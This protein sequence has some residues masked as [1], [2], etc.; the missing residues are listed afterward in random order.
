GDGAITPRYLGAGAARVIGVDIDE[1]GIAR[2]RERHSAGGAEFLPSAPDRIPLADGSVEVIVS[3]D[4]FE[5]IRQPAPVLAEFHRVLRDGGKVL[6]G[7]WG[8]YHPF[9]PHLF[10]A[11]PVPWAH[12]FFSERTVLRTCRRVYNAPWYVPTMHDLDECGGKRADKYT[13]EEI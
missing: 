12:V 10:A 4:V 13:E 9:A 2:A 8:W 11:M 7:T 5:H 1:K 6:I 3:Y